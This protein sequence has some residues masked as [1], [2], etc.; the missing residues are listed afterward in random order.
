MTL[1]HICGKS[2]CSF[3]WGI[4]VTNAGKMKK[5]G[6]VPDVVRLV[7]GEDDLVVS[8][9]LGHSSGTICFFRA[10]GLWR[11][12]VSNSCMSCVLLRT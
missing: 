12:C 8:S 11:A 3:Q 5:E 9:Q 1:A 6:G 10:H 4:G 2:G 7:Q